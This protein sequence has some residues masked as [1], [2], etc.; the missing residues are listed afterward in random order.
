[1]LFSFQELNLKNVTGK[2]NLK[3]N[4]KI[5]HKFDI[6]PFENVFSYLDITRLQNTTKEEEQMDVSLDD[7]VIC[8][9][10]TVVENVQV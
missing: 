8:L 10:D 4:V 1:M 6:K 3:G 7:S 2:D 5:N 9:N